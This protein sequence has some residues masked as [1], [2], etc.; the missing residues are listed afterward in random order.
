MGRGPLAM[1]GLT[2]VTLRGPAVDFPNAKTPIPIPSL[3]P[4]RIILGALV[5]RADAGRLSRSSGGDT[6]KVRD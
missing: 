5:P 1:A 3:G 4:V 2:P 6:N